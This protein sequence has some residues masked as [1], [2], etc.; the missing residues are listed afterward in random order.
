M[1]RPGLRSKTNPS[2]R[3]E[4]SSGPDSFC[5][6]CAVLEKQ[7]RAAKSDT[8]VLRLENLQLREENVQLN[9]LNK[10]LLGSRNTRLREKEGQ[11]VALRNQLDETIEKAKQLEQNLHW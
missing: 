10:K 9:D 8:E 7:L 11:N 2:P 6:R 4:N 3:R 1:S 5:A